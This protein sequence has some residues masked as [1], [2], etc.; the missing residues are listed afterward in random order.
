MKKSFV[1][2]LSVTMATLIITSFPS[3]ADVLFST[4]YIMS[5][6]FGTSNVAHKITHTLGF[7]ETS[8][9]SSTDLWNFSMQDLTVADVGSTFNINSATDGSFNLLVE[10]LTDG[11]NEYFA[12]LASFGTGTGGSVSWES[13]FFGG[14]SSS[15]NGIDFAGY[16]ID[17]LSITLLA[18]TFENPIDKNSGDWTDYEATFG[19]NIHGAAIP[20]PASAALIG[21]FTGGIYFVRRFFV[22]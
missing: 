19:M 2:Q 15:T 21:L 3:H 7:S 16:T 14:S 9:G 6:G 1:V 5:G 20:E 8:S 17:S 18:L 4:D 10:A 22:V 13:I 12:R 11:D